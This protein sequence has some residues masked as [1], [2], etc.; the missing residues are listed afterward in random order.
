M[1]VSIHFV[2]LN[3]VLGSAIEAT[4]SEPKQY[5]ILGEITVEDV[6]YN[7]LLLGGNL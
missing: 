1:P 6:F 4:S 7:G 5:E 3:A 2:S